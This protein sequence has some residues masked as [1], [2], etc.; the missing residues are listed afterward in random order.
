MS[1]IV[2]YNL[3]KMIQCEPLTLEIRLV[4]LLNSIEIQLIDLSMQSTIIN[5]NTSHS[6]ERTGVLVGKG[7]DLVHLITF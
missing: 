3:H 6:E 2:I 4:L 5:A 7:S 1:H